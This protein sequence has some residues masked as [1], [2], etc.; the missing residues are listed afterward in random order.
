MTSGRRKVTTLSER[1]LTETGE[2][3]Q[4]ETK[5]VATEADDQTK[6]T[7]AAPGTH[8]LLA[9]VAPGPGLALPSPGIPPLHDDP[10]DPS[11]G[12]PHTRRRKRGR[13]RESQVPGLIMC[14]VCDITYIHKL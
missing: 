7:I 13:G 11:V 4:R 14:L 5:T 10:H 6:E 1:S 12:P 3:G 8:A 2:T 9:E